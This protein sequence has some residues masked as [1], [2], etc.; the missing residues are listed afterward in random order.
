MNVPLARTY[1]PNGTFIPH[2]F[3]TMARS[4]S[5]GR[6]AGE[7]SVVSDPQGRNSPARSPG[8]SRRMSERPVVSN[9]QEMNVPLART[10]RPNGT[11]IRFGR[12]AKEVRTDEHDRADP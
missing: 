5:F 8:V 9:L 7:R 1:R 2:G 6:H 10:Y 3:E 11:F 12:R 4:L